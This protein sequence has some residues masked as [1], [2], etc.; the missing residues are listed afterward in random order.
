M[1]TP[2]QGHKCCPRD[3]M[4]AP[5]QRINSTTIAVVTTYS[6]WRRWG[7]PRMPLVPVWRYYLPVYALC[8]GR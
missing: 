1:H 3:T 6:S 7:P 8:G 4:I 2:P 5:L